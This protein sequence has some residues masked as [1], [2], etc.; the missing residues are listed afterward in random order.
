MLI[1]IVN[2][3]SLL[4]IHYSLK[5]GEGL[6]PNERKLRIL[7]AIV[8]TYAE[9]GEPVGSKI[10]AEMLGGGVS[11]A[12]V[13]NDMA[14]LSASGYIEQ[15]HTSAGRIPSQRGYRLYVDRL[16]SRRALPEET[17]QDIDMRL[18]TYS[19]D[20]SG[21]LSAAAQSLSDATGMTS[22]ITTPSDDDAKV[23]NIELIQGGSN[24]CLL[25]MM[26]AP[27]V[28]KTRLVRV[29][30]EL[31]AEML[32]SLRQL[33][34]ETVKGRRL[35]EVDRRMLLGIRQVLGESGIVLEPLLSAL[36][37]SARDASKV[38]IMLSGISKLLSIDDH[39][40]SRDVI[41]FLSNEERLGKLIASREG[42]MSVSIGRE[43]MEDQ[44]AQASMITARYRGGKDAAGW[45][46]IIGDTR[47]SYQKIIPHIEYFSAAV[48]RMMSAL[49]N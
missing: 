31:S 48:G 11:S 21:F 13:R 25:I 5:R 36:R 33:L 29:N 47:M 49:D 20:P 28:L 17:M 8:E 19:M 12:T 42:T 6:E 26:I 2:N 38:S 44:M 22:I 45:V 15:P 10:L 46:G 27:S 39:E 14:A 32:M 24:S 30:T 37:E 34:C 41:S 23:R 1:R 40:A 35:K 4:L 18:T 16:M 9:T 3:Y 43:M 7:A